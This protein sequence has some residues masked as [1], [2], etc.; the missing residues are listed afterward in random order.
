M[1]IMV[2]WGLYWG[3]FFGET[4]IRMDLPGYLGFRVYGLEIGVYKDI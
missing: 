3:L 4:I 1:R 2:F